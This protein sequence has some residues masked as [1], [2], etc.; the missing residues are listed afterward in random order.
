MMMVT[1]G[2]EKVSIKRPHMSYRQCYGLIKVDIGSSIY[3]YICMQIGTM[4][5]APG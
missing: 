5:L 3:I 1:L 4:F 2:C